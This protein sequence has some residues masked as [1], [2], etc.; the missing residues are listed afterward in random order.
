MKLSWDN[1]RDDV[2]QMIRN[3]KSENEVRG[4]A[5]ELVR[6]A[7]RSRSRQYIVGAMSKGLDSAV[8]DLNTPVNTASLNF[9]FAYEKISEKSTSYIDRLINDVDKLISKAY[10]ESTM[11]DRLLLVVGAFNSN[12][13]RLSFIAK[14]ELYRA[15]NYGRAVAARE[16]GLDTVGVQ[17][18]EH[19]CEECIGKVN[20]KILL[21][22]IDLIEA[23]PPHH[24][25]CTCL[26]ELNMPAEEV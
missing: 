3:G 18:H 24:P 16:I 10:G 26:V 23:V 1:L 12:E 7:L 15:Y 11:T 20:D 2:V 6:Q 14:T 25:N 22:D 5:T 21:T 8:R 19:G 9:S 13:Y 4:F 17:H